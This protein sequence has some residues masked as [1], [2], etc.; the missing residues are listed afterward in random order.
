MQRI[1]LIE[2]RMVENAH[3]TDSAHTKVPYDIPPDGHFRC[4]FF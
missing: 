1:V 4:I 2:I 3:E